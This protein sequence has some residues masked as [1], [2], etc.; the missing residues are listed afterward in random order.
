MRFVSAT[1]NVAKLRFKPQGLAGQFK[2][3]FSR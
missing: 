1:M 3:L 2:T